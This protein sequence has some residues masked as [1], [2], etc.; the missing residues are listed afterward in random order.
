MTNYVSLNGLRVI[1]GA[2]Q[3]KAR[4]IKKKYPES[5]ELEN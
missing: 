5:R 3:S 4:C 2:N 1:E